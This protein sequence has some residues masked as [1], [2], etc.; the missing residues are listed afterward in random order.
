M[1]LR[2]L[3]RGLILSTLLASLLGPVVGARAQTP[4]PPTQVRALLNAMTPEER[5]GQL[6]LVTFSGTDT[7]V[8]IADP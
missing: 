5:V 7:G 1:G 2:R 8:R 3:F 4:T 6:L